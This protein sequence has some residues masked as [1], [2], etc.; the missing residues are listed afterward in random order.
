MMRQL[1]G[2]HRQRTGTLARL[3]ALLLAVSPAANGQTAQIPNAS[4]SDGNDVNWATVAETYSRYFLEPTEPVEAATLVLPWE[5]TRAVVVA[6]PLSDWK[7]RPSESD[8]IRNLLVELLPHVTVV[9]VYRETDYRLLGDWL[10]EMETDA[11]ISPHLQNLELVGGEVFSIWA[12]DFSPLF[13]RERS[14]RIVL[15]D[16]SFLAARRMMGLLQEAKSHSDPA[17]QHLMLTQ[18]SHELKG[19]RGTDIFPSSLAAFLQT[20][21]GYDIT[22]TRPPLY[23]LGGDFLPVDEQSALVSA[24]TLQE[25]GGRSAHLS[26]VLEEYVGVEKIVY[27]ENLPGD[28]IEHLDFVVQPIAPGVILTAAPPPNFGQ[29]RP[30]HRYL[31]RELSGRLQRNRERLHQAFPDSAIIDVPMPPPLVDDDAK[32]LEEL[33]FRCVEQ[34]AADGNLP[35]WSAGG[36]E[37][38]EPRNLDPKLRQALQA[39]FGGL[40]LRDPTDQQVAVESFLGRP[41]AGLVARHVEEHVRY[42]SYINSLYLRTSKTELVLVPRYRASNEQEE[43]LITRMETEVREA[44][45]RALPQADFRWVD[46]T[47]LV[48]FLGAVHCLTATIP[49]PIP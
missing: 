45:R 6:I 15:V 34:I 3:T 7:R 18:A 13:A 44:Y 11:T 16:P 35:F 2:S 40:D 23:L 47:G 27:L 10:R 14:G 41:V 30:F 9:G 37:A 17:S 39:E 21:F 42:R 24:F 43:A 5:T 20:R 48:D 1:L 29:N 46:C 49:A 12:R 32:V 31:N 8:T 36:W 28:T 19:M 26:T 22:L 4:S 38:F 33:L 25:N